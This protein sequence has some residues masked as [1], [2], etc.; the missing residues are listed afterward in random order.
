[1]PLPEGGKTPWPPPECEPIYRQYAVWGAWWS[2]DH[3]QLA[4]IYSGDTNRDTTGFFASETGG[5]KA[6]ARRVVDTV[7]RWFWGSTATSR[8]PRQRVHVPLAADIAQAS[9]ALL[10]SE[11]PNFIAAEPKP[12]A[13]E[14]ATQAPAE[15]TK[16]SPD[17]LAKTQERLNLYREDARQTLLEGADICAGLG[18]V[19]LRVTWNKDL[20][21]RP[22]CDAVHPDTAVPEWSGR[23]LT[24]VTYWRVIR[25]TALGQVVRHLERHSRGLIENAVYIGTD[26]KIGAQAP[27]DTYDA[28]RDLTPEFKTGFDG[29]TSAYVPNIRPAKVWRGNTYAAALGAADIAGCEDM[30]DALDLIE[31]SWM[32]DVDL[33]KARLLVPKQ[34]LMSHGPGNSASVDLDQEVYEGLNTLDDSAKVEQVQFKIRWQEHKETSSAF[35]QD[36]V[37]MAGYSPQTFGLTGEVAITATEV[38]AKERRSLTT[39]DLKAGYWTPELAGIFHAMLHIDATVFGTDVVVAAPTIEWPDAVSVD[40]EAMART[41]REYEAAGAM[42]TE[43]KVRTIHPD[44]DDPEITEEVE[45]IHKEKNIGQPLPEPGFGGGFGDKPPPTDDEDED[46]DE[47]P[48]NDGPPAA[49]GE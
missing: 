28:T 15:D 9:A 43:T 19:F 44:W 17:A 31:S 13:A 16:A 4:A 8:Q 23:I 37:Q 25:K 47:P 3:D 34:M 30:L 46:E 11:P 48:G 29:L 38:A 35:K 40:P 7:K 6:T 1:M 5:F 18:G 21:D 10:F 45:R 14:D 20:R 24:A 26:E 36:I 49:G 12:A 41:L 33:G 32:R 39:R 22:W 2:A 27:L 42:S